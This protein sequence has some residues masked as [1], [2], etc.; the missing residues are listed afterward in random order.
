[1]FGIIA[2]A[3]VAL[4]QAFAEVKTESTDSE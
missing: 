2:V 3:L 4:A 1:V